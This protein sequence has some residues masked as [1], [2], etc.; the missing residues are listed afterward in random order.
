MINKQSDLP[1]ITEH[2]ER[3]I[4]RLDFGVQQ[5]VETMALSEINRLRD[6]LEKA[7]AIIKSGDTA[8]SEEVLAVEVVPTII[9]R[10]F[11]PHYSTS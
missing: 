2:L 1:D 7:Q 4:A 9:W 6:A 5:L 10:S 3:S 8:G 11:A